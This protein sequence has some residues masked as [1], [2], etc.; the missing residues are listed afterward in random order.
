MQLP[1]VLCIWINF[2]SHL[3]SATFVRKWKCFCYAPKVGW[4]CPFRFIFPAP[5]TQG[6]SVNIGRNEWS[7]HRGGKLL[8]HSLSA[9]ICLDCSGTLDR[10]CC[11]LFSMILLGFLLT[12]WLSLVLCYLFL[13]I[14]ALNGD[15]SL[16]VGE[17]NGNP[18]QY[19]CLENP[20]DR[21]AWQGTVHGVAKSW[22]RLRDYHSLPPSQLP[23]FS[24]H[25]PW[26]I[27]SSFVTSAITMQTWM[28]SK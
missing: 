16:P 27:S 23:W 25:S 2:H 17:G 3:Q 11:D 21:G 20:M 7:L 8:E 6:T 28:A 13:F 18:L 9:L 12:F 24:G 14:S 26:M 4:C 15:T 5:G 22:T 19:S 10:L 1:P